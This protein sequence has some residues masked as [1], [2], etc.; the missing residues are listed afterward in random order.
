MDFFIDCLLDAFIDSI[1]LVPF[2]IVIYI[3]IELLTRKAGNR[4]AMAVKKAG[5]VGPLIGGAVGVIPQCGLSAAAATL[6]SDKVITVGTMLAVFLSASDDMLPILI[7]SSFP[8]LSI[9]KLLTVKMCIGIFMGYMVDIA[10]KVFV[11]KKDANNKKAVR[12]MG[13]KQVAKE[14]QPICMQSCCVGP[15]WLVVIKRTA[16]VFAYIFALSLLLNIVIELIGEDTLASLFM[17]IPVL[18]HMISALIGLIPNCASSVIITELF[19]DEVITTGNLFAGLLVNAGVGILVLI[20]SNKNK[21]ETFTVIG[22][23]YVIGVLWGVLIDLV[24]LTF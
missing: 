9:G 15:F 2:L 18:G 23:L 1:K 11:R 20:R 22:V 4:I 16:Q 6:F 19:L 14:S 12:I 21:K 5:A 13:K 8:V 17:N 7:S 10:I 24:G 3:L